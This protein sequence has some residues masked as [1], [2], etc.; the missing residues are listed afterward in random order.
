LRTRHLP[1]VTKRRRFPAE[2]LDSSAPNKIW[3]PVLACFLLAAVLAGGFF[4]DVPAMATTAVSH[5]TKFRI[6]KIAPSHATVTVN[7]PDDKVLEIRWAGTATFP[8]TAYTTPA[9]GCS[10]D[11]FTCASGQQTFTHKSQ[12]LAWAGDG[13]ELWCEGSL[14]RTLTF[15]W[16]VYLVDA[17]QRRTPAFRLTLNCQP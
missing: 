14:S 11:D 16:N 7:R 5:T 6:V 10:H 1:A 8:V 12:V 3:T 15:A 17:K 4:E 2:R 9:V 13:N